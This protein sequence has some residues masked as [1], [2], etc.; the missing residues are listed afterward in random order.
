MWSIRS[1]PVNMLDRIVV[2]EIGE[3]WSPKTEPP[4]T[5]PKQIFTKYGSEWSAQASGN[6]TGKTTA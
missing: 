6:A 3:H 1:Q 2:S 4:S 5:A